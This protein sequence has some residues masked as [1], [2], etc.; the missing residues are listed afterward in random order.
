MTFVFDITS[1]TKPRQTRADVWKKR[2]CVMK[3]RAF[4]DEVR[5]AKVQLPPLGA[6]IVFH[7]PMPKS[8]SKK[9]R[10]AMN[11]NTHKQRPDCEDLWKILA[12]AIYD[13]DAHTH[14]VRIS[15]FWAKNDT[16]NSH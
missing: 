16:Y 13:M 9:K 3:Y 12:D 11:G 15:K 6:Y 2:P 1:V 8:W 5:A 4:A 10:A 7:L 14:D